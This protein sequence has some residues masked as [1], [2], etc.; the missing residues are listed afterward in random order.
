M[1][2]GTIFNISGSAMNAQTQRLSVVA[3]N[4]ANANSLTSSNGGP[5]RAREVVFAAVPVAGAASSMARGVRVLG[6]VH[7]NAP[8]RKVYDPGSPFANGKGYVTYPNVN[9]I[10]EMINMISAS[11]SYTADAN[12][13]NAAKALYLKALTL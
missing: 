1:G 10:D 8:M 12:V 13:M 6:V 7:S 5:Y 2:L 4:L 9:P 11:R 3:S